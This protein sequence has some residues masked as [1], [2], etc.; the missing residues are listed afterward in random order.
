[1]PVNYHILLLGTYWIFSIL[2][3]TYFVNFFHFFF[4][5]ASNY[6]KI[7]D[8]IYTLLT[9]KYG[10]NLLNAPV[11]SVLHQNSRAILTAPG[12]VQT[13]F[14][15][16]LF[17]HTFYI[18]KLSLT[19]I[20]KCRFL[21]WNVSVQVRFMYTSWYF[22]SILQGQQSIHILWNHLPMTNWMSWKFFVF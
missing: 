13:C 21:L 8:F 22:Y 12:S 18:C 10:G 20:Q 16:V 5:S 11:S 3:V 15:I 2:L 7:L 9:L 17:W 4:L 19:Q 1:M 14:P 6:S